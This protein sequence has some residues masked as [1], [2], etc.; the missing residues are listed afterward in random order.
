MNCEF[1]EKLS[2][3]MAKS[4]RESGS[5]WLPV[6]NTETFHGITVPRARGVNFTFCGIA[7][8]SYDQE[9]EL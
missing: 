2:A 1:S 9:K 3:V 4:D 7:D 8:N 5:L 6:T